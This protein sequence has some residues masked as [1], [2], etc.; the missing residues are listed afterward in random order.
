M[1]EKL[2]KIFNSNQ[3]QNIESS[4]IIGRKTNQEDCFY[5][6]ESKNNQRLVFVA[7]GVGGHSHGEFASNKTVEIFNEAFSHIS[8]KEIIPDFLR[9]TVYQAARAVLE[10]GNQDNE[11]KNCGTTI[12][13]F[14]ITGNAYYTINIGDSRVYL[15]NCQTL[16]RETHDHSIVQQLIDS[17]Q[18][19]EAEAFT[20]PKRNIM[21]SAIGQDL[22]MM[23]IDIQGPRNLEH[24]DILM[25][26]SDGVH[27][28]LTDEQIFQ[29]V[30]HYQNTQGL[31]DALT[32]AAYNAGGKDNITAV[33]Y[34][35][36]E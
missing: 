26:F 30:K 16:C 21:T 28:A 7:D 25:A 3:S 24:G 36:F 13:G 12:S 33:I 17:G 35:F 27:D 15:W 9:N 20:H 19:T 32:T 14:F 22:A 23:K 10:Q 2:K 34:R 5:I 29:I 18:I 1:L 4:S 31:A 11:Y 8:E 6:S